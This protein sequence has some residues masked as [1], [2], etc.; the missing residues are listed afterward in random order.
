MQTGSAA[1]NDANR[2]RRCPSGL[3]HHDLREF[4]N[5]AF[6]R[7]HAHHDSDQYSLLGPSKPAVEAMLIDVSGPDTRKAIYRINYWSNNLAI[8]VAGMIGGFFFSDYLFELLL[9]ASVMS[10]VAL[11]VTAFSWQ[12][13][14]QPR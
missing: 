13:R 7:T 1:K 14:C 4:T 6:R 5:L 11:L 10:L 8:S 9:V 12:K 3:C 2:G